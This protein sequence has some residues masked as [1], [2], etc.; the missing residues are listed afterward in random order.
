MGPGTTL[1]PYLPTCLPACLPAYMPTC[2]PVYLPIRLP[3]YLPLS[4]SSLAQGVCVSSHLR[5]WAGGEGDGPFAVTPQGTD[6]VAADARKKGATTIPPSTDLGPGGAWGDSRSVP[7]REVSGLPT[8]APPH[9]F[10]T[11]PQLQ[12]MVGLQPTTTHQTR[13]NHYHPTT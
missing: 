7:V 9:H 3:A 8:T 11:P 5:A 2:L 1:D 4:T 10:P 6:L 12:T 13:Q